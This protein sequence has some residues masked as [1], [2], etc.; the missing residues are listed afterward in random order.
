MRNFVNNLSF[1]RKK[2]SRK[3]KVLNPQEEQTSKDA[4]PTKKID[5]FTSQIDKNYLRNARNNEK[6][7]RRSSFLKSLSHSVLSIEN[8]NHNTFTAT[9]KY[10][11]NSS[12]LYDWRASKFGERNV[13]NSVL[14][15]KFITE[16]SKEKITNKTKRKND[17]D[18]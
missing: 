18:T 13:R 17:D 11:I 9:T 8:H 15:S 16:K 12:N 4:S 5:R 10:Q 7:M 2:Q 6:I 14:D 3:E 1:G